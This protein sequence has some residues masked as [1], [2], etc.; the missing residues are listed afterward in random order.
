MI[1]GHH[2]NLWP[3]QNFGRGAR[4]TQRWEPN[5]PRGAGPEHVTEIVLPARV[6]VTAGSTVTVLAS[7][8]EG[9]NTVAVRESTSQ[10]GRTDRMG[11]GEGLLRAN[12]AEGGD[13]G[14]PA[15]KRPRPRSRGG[16]PGERRSARRAVACQ[17]LAEVKDLAVTREEEEG[18]RSMTTRNLLRC[19]QLSLSAERIG[20][21]AEFAVKHFIQPLGVAE[22]DIAGDGGE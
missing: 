15:D 18:T 2:R 12:P 21:D 9:S 16:E 1:A 10:A 7:E 19:L 17:P 22:P 5:R 3:F 8:S 4:R 6:E 20:A 13:R 11:G 14:P